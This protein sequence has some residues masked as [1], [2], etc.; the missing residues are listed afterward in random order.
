MDGNRE[1]E[2]M[3]MYLKECQ[4]P[5]SSTPLCSEMEW[6]AKIRPCATIAVLLHKIQESS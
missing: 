4:R 5:I 1:L 3:A 6:K 2:L